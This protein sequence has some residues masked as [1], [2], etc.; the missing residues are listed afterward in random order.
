[1]DT[2]PIH[3]FLEALR[4]SDGSDLH[5][6]PGHLPHVRKNGILRPLAD[7]A[8]S[9]EQIVCL[10]EP[11]TPARIRTAWDAGTPADFAYEANGTGRF[12]V[13]AYRSRRGRGAVIR[14]VPRELPSAEDL[15]CRLPSTTSFG[16]GVDWCWLRGRRGRENQRRS[17][18]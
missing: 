5:L 18:G 4:Q 1:M 15:D 3:D 6:S 10:L 9:E 16:C 8:L 17:R 7:E 14:A 11:I 2:L 13:N 12:R